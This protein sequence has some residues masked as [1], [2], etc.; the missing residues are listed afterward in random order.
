EIQTPGFG[1]NLDGLLRD[2]SS[3]LSGILNGVDYAIWSPERDAVLPQ[4]YARDGDMAGKAAAKAE[5]QRRLGLDVDPKAPLFGAVTR[6][7]WQKG[8]DLVLGALL[9][10]VGLG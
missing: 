5:L 10:L 3:A 8:F 2:R 9:G 4:S 1:M 6:L 7:T